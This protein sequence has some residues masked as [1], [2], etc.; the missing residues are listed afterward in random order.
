MQTRRHFLVAWLG[1]FAAL[2]AALYGMTEA[3]RWAMAEL[4]T[5]EARERQR[6]WQDEALRQSQGSGPVRR[7]PVKANEPPMLIL[8]RDH[9]G[10]AAATNLIAVTIFYWFFTFIIR[11]MLRAKQS[12]SRP[13]QAERAVELIAGRSEPKR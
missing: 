3:R 1:Y 9:F 5:P 7:R 11:G 8:L 12:L 6:V 10:A 2:A 4:D 13:S